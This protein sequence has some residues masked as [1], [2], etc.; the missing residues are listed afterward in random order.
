MSLNT[1]DIPAKSSTLQWGKDF[2]ADGLEHAKYDV[3]IGG[4]ITY[5]AT[6][7]DVLFETLDRFSHSATII[8]ICHDNDSCPLSPRAILKFKDIARR[9]N[10]VIDDLDTIGRAHV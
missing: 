9:Y 1:A 2:P 10:F 4:D 5:D 7:F 6:A 8:Y 3:I